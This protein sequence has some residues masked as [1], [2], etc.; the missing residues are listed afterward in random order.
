MGDALVEALAALPLT[1]KAELLADQEAHPPYG[2]N[3][4]APL[5][6][7]V[8]LHQTSGTTGRPLRWLDTAESWGWFVRCWRQVYVGAGIS[9]ASGLR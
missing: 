7:F 8:R 5:D 4:G 2:T 9:A 3:L 6:R 1:R